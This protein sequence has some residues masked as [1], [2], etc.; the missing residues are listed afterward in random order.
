MLKPIIETVVLFGRQN[1]PLRGHCDQGDFL[2][3]TNH[4]NSSVVNEGNF[5]E[6]LRLR[7]S[8][9][10]KILEN[11]LQTTTSKATYISHTTQ[12]DIIS[13][14]KDEIIINILENVKVSKYYSIIFDETTDVSHTSQ[15]S[16]ILRNVYSE[17]KVYERF[18]SFIDCHSH[19]YGKT[20]V[21]VGLENIEDEPGHNIL[22]PKL[23]EE[24]LG[25][26]VI[27]K[28]KEITLD[29]D[30]FI[31][32]GTDGCLMMTSIMQVAV[33][34]IQKSCKNALHSSWSNHA[35]NLLISKS[36]NVQLVR[37][38]MGIIQEVLSFFNQS[39]KR[40]FVLKKS[41]KGCKRSLTSLCD[42]RWVERHDSIFEFQSNFKNIIL[43]LESIS[44]WDEQISSSKA[45]CLLNVICNCEFVIT[46]I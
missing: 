7:I 2:S 31:G 34:K 17:N 29:L 39:S 33:Q 10:D 11:H 26:I 37:N 30:N 41:L 40:S 21:N 9:G 38:I 6:L 5:R 36:S 13:C 43:C 28:L 45:K 3:F 20:N 24:L 32:I 35:L 18:I 16:L 4:H 23:S 27:D 44:E 1:I 19:V 46:S 12:E 22:E 8:A 15:M 42:T 25:N 14:C